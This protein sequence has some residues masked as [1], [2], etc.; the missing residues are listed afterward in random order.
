MKNRIKY[1][2]FITML[3]IGL[4]FVN[5]CKKGPGE[6]G[7]ASIKG[8][9]FTTNYNSSFTIPSDSGYIGGENVYI[10]YGDETMVGDNQD[11][12]NEGAYEFKYLR[13]GRY[14]VYVFTKTAVN[15][16]DTAIVQEIEIFDKKQV[17]ELPDFRIRTTKN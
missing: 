14:K 12:N 7:R 3:A 4:I 11:T 1:F 2:F 5:S 9:V 6:G 10:I 15:H 8:K 13:K 16:I 17:V